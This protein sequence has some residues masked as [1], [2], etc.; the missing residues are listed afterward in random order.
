MAKDYASEEYQ[1]IKN[2]LVSSVNKLVS[3]MKELPSKD[4]VSLDKLD[5]LK[6]EFDDAY[7]ALKKFNLQ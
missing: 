5:P 1:E 4:K 2:D 6:K 3:F 7:Q